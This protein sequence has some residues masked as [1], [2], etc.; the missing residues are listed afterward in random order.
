MRKF[1]IE[2][3][4]ALVRKMPFS[5]CKTK[6]ARKFAKH[7][8]GYFKKSGLTETVYRTMSFDVG[9][10]DGVQWKRILELKNGDRIVKFH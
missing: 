1:P 8:F 6:H 2:K 4:H 9:D 3:H 10:G 5:P 7:Q